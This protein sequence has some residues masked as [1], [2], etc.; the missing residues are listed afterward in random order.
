[1]M[2]ISKILRSCLDS[3][4]AYIFIKFYSYFYLLNIKK[5]FSTFLPKYKF[6]SF[7]NEKSEIF[8]KNVSKNNNFWEK[9]TKIKK[10]E[11]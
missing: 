4:L 7:K 11:F 9:N 3:S 5:I 2:G 1:M 10:N 8:M 6:G